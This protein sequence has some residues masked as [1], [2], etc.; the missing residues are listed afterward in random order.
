MALYSEDA[1]LNLWYLPWPLV[2]QTLSKQHYF[3]VKH[4]LTTYYIFRLWKNLKG[5]TKNLSYILSVYFILIVIF[6]E[7]VCS[8]QDSQSTPKTTIS[9]W[10]HFKCSDKCDRNDPV[11]CEHLN[12]YT[13]FKFKHYLAFNL[14]RALWWFELSNII[15]DDLFAN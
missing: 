3:V 1:I 8:I 14:F 10:C 6:S 12:V 4:T 11:R 13:T 2:K 9:S 15:C 5:F 7:M